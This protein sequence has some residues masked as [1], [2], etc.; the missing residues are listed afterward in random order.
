MDVDPLRVTLCRDKVRLFELIIQWAQ[1]PAVIAIITDGPSTDIPPAITKE[2]DNFLATLY[3]EWLPAD[4]DRT[5]NTSDQLQWSVIFE[6]NKLADF[7]QF[8]QLSSMV[9]KY[10]TKHFPRTASALMALFEMKYT[11][12]MVDVDLVRSEFPFLQATGLPSDVI[13]T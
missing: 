6:V 4:V 3:R 10:M 9:D 7:F 8:H 12:T 2:E 11:F 5:T 13:L 1:S